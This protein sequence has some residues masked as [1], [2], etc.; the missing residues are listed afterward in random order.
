MKP[1]WIH[2]H[3]TGIA[4]VGL[5]LVDVDLFFL[6]IRSTDDFVNETKLS[7]LTFFSAGK[8]IFLLKTMGSLHHQAILLRD[9]QFFVNEFKL[10]SLTKMRRLRK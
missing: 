1:N 4:P 7:S 8:R 5:N 2:E 9:H 6:N 10:N 3:F